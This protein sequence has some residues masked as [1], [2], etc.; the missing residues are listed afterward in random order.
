M[1][2]IDEKNLKKGIEKLFEKTYK[3]INE[4]NTQGDK[5]KKSMKEALDILKNFDYEINVE[6]KT[7]SFN[8]DK[9]P[10]ETQ[11]E[12]VNSLSIY[13]NAV[14]TVDDLKDP[15]KIIDAIEGLI[16]KYEALA[17]NANGME[18]GN[19]KE[20][21][22]LK[23]DLENE[24]GKLETLNENIKT[25]IT[26]LGL[27]EELKKPENKGRELEIL[28]KYVLE[29][30]KSQENAKNKVKKLTKSNKGWIIG[31]AAVSV[32]G[33]LGWTYAGIHSGIIKDKN[34]IIEKY[35]GTLGNIAD[36]LKDKGYEE[37]LKNNGFSDEDLNTL[38]GLL[39]GLD[40]SEKGTLE[41]LQ[42]YKDTFEALN[43]GLE[44]EGYSYIKEDGSFDVE[45]LVEDLEMQ[46]YSPETQ[47]A[48]DKFKAFLGQQDEDLTEDNVVNLVNS[49]FEHLDSLATLDGKLDDLFTKLE[50]VDENGEAIT[51][52]TFENREAAYN[53]ISNYINK[54]NADS[55]DVFDKASAIL[56]DLGNTTEGTSLDV[57]GEIQNE[58]D[59][60]QLSIDNNKKAYEATYKAMAEEMLDQI[61][62]SLSVEDLQF[63]VDSN[64][65]GQITESEKISAAI[66]FVKE[67][68]QK[69]KEQKG[70]LEGDGG[71]NGGGENFE[72]EETDTNQT[73][74]QGDGSQ[75]DDASLNEGK[76]QEP[77]KGNSNNNDSEFGI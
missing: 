51:L 11:K 29:T 60:L 63:N 41:E 31:F 64:E 43:A 30:L 68:I 36:T 3:V 25:L 27:E 20:I 47:E 76:P 70:E 53:Y 12:I 14:K 7:I 42:S 54:M 21:E 55:A 49:M 2:N 40:I 28:K 33:A 46:E 37:Y 38:R 23:A 59:K 35:E 1:A 62:P 57:L 17:T 4:I 5:N 50:V 61:N 8:F 44:K 32:L 66:E 34:A 9:V 48:Y 52:S 67:E 72:E 39:E 10:P 58:V 65:D 71:Y 75:N 6:E 16:N 45:G 19:K 69:L 15:T 77:G 22:K 26:E 18:K 24:K 56:S 74:N 13:S 73:V